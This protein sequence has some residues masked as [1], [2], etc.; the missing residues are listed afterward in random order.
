MH[1]PAAWQDDQVLRSTTGSFSIDR[2]TRR[3]GNTCALLTAEP[4]TKSETT[5]SDYRPH[6][7]SRPLAIFST[8]TWLSYSRRLVNKGEEATC[9]HFRSFHLGSGLK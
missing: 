1:A 4:G 5:R 8:E 9:K 2:H 6:S 3:L 7:F